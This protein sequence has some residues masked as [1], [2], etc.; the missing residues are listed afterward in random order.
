MRK[1]FVAG[2]M[3]VAGDS[4]TCGGMNDAWPP[5]T[6]SEYGSLRRPMDDCKVVRGL[7]A[8]SA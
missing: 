1:L 6:L 8:F 4:G 5:V 2:D 3:F 7:V